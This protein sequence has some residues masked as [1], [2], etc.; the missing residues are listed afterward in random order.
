MISRVWQQDLICITK[1]EENQRL[2]Q[3][4]LE[5][6]ALNQKSLIDQSTVILNEG[7]EVPIYDTHVRCDVSNQ[8]STLNRTCHLEIHEPREIWILLT[9]AY[10]IINSSLSAVRV[11]SLGKRVMA[12]HLCI[13]RRVGL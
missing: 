13:K 3:V 8:R 11:S 2:I 1:R 4:F 5:H 12:T 7:N 9:M 6:V 10:N